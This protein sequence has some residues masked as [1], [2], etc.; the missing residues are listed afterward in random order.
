VL[1][2]TSDSGLALS[3]AVTS[4]LA[5]ISGNTVT[6]TGVGVV[7]IQAT[8]AGNSTY[9]P[10]TPVSQSF[11]VGLR[12]AGASLTTRSKHPIGP[13]TATNCSRTAPPRLRPQAPARP[14]RLHSMRPATGISATEQT[15]G[16]GSVRPATAAPRHPRRLGSASR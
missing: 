11:T 15:S 9:A 1:I 3:Y 6:V 13:E 5:T 14:V 10:A 7:T 8:Q 4:G 16:G 2:G 12:S